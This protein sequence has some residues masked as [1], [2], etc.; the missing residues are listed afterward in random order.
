MRTRGG[1]RACRGT[2]SLVP[3]HA[4]S[5]LLQPVTCQG[6]VATH[7]A[8]T[9]PPTSRRTMFAPHDDAMDALF[10]ELN[11]TIPDFASRYTSLAQQL[12][13]CACACLGEATCVKRGGCT[14]VSRPTNGAS[15]GSHIPPALLPGTKFC[16]A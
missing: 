10:T 15:A 9:L 14:V 6:A 4:G 12:I 11:I 8:A 7:P 13:R 2:T 16:R 1:C 5:W 3:Q